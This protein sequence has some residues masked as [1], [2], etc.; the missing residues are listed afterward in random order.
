MKHLAAL[1]ILFVG[2]PARGAEA[3]ASDP[4]VRLP[5]A[6]NA[7][8]NWPSYRG[9]RG[10]GLAEGFSTPERWNITNGE[11]IRWK[12]PLP[13]LGLSSPCIWGN[14]LYVTTAVAA[15]DQS[16]KIGL[17]G[18]I[19]AAA[20]AGEQQ[21]RVLCLDKESGKLIWDRTASSGRPKI[22]RHT[23]SSHANATVAT[24]GRHVVAHFGSEGLY[25]YD[26]GG[27]L[28]WKKNFGVLD[29][30][31]FAVPSAQWGYGS[32]PV[33]HEGKLILQCD[34]QTNSFVAAY[35]LRDGRELWRTAR[36]EVPTWCTPTVAEWN[37]R[38]QI[39]CNGYHV[40]A[41]YD[42]GSGRELWRLGGGGDIPVPT[43]V[44]GQGLA[45]LCS[46][47][48]RLSPLYA[49][50]L[51]AEGDITLRENALTNAH[52]AWSVPR[53]GSYLQTPVLVGDELYLCNDLGLLSCYNARTGERHYQERLSTGGNSF[54]A[55]PIA[56]DGK[57][58]CTAENGRVYVAALGQRFELLAKNELAEICLATPAIS[59]GTIY[60]RTQGHLIAITEKPA[61]AR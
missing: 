59:A 38:T 51:S 24:D 50:R 53:G 30:G 48:G 14:R 33:I 37:G 55:S 58:Y 7:E 2:M 21:W 12:T 10:G 13:G 29:S 39:I 47:H 41:G 54:T 45:Y 34:V 4:A 25:C 16:L 15:G 31:Y 26:A 27:A 42:F 20:D 56:A 60:F 32:S 35:D 57:I 40:H 23:K 17:Y 19:G 3:R 46:A 6:P 18:D 8:T 52:I 1:L 28:L 22:K 61:A 36:A 44:I 9:T 5:P 11:N 43:P 49:V